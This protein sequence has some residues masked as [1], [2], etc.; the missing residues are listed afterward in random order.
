MKKL[1][2]IILLL[3]TACVSVHRDPNGDTT[4]RTFGASTTTVTTE[5]QI[6]T[7]SPGVSEGIADF[8]KE[9]PETVL[10]VL[11]ALGGGFA[12]LSK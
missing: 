3:L 12:A 1:F 5:G 2:L 11:S 7:T 10:R 4:V 8:L 6:T 9:I